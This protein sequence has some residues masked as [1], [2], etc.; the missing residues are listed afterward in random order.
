MEKKR[1]Y[2]RSKKSEKYS[3]IRRKNA[4]K[5]QKSLKVTLIIVLKIWKCPI[6]MRDLRE[7]QLWGVW[8]GGIF[9][10]NG[11]DF[12]C[13]R[14]GGVRVYLLLWLLSCDNFVIFCGFYSFQNETLG[15]KH[16]YLSHKYKAWGS[17]QQSVELL[18]LDIPKY[19]LFFS[20]TEALNFTLGH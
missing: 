7:N 1:T 10:V 4:E 19:E 20:K 5:Y 16:E 2:Y 6:I 15:A 18:I 14:G 12:W 8:G 11:V 17:Q 3:I 13:K 9:G